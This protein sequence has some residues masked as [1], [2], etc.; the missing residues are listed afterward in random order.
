MALTEVQLA[1]LEHD[2][3]LHVPEFLPAAAISP[4]VQELVATVDEGATL[5]MREG[6]LQR[7]EF[8]H[9][10]G[11][12]FSQRLAALC[13]ATGEPPN[14]Y[15]QLAASSMSKNHKTEALFELL[16]YPQLLDVVE[17]VIGGEILCHPQWN[18]RA[19]LPG[20]HG[21]LMHQDINLLDSSCEFTP[22]VNLWIPLVDT[23]EHSGCLRVARGSH[24]KGIL[25]Y[26][27]KDGIPST[28]LTGCEIVSCPTAARG[29]VIFTQLLAH[30]SFDQSTLDFVRWSMDIRYSVLGMPTGRDEVPGFVARSRKAPDS[31]TRSAEEWRALIDAVPG[32]STVANGVAIRDL[33]PRL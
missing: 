5:A 23:N 28:A 20:D 12:P 6:R 9:S 3:F 30:G 31:V 21:A 24:R 16:T 7:T 15:P 10:R 13:S 18:I 4:L 22:M 2:G 19:S 32:A 25:P 33:A 11:L 17:S 14:H 29:A 26:S 27:A 1:R 8:D